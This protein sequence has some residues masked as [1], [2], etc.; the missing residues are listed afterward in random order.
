MRRLVLF[1]AFMLAACATTPSPK[2]VRY[3][4]APAERL[5]P[6]T[7]AVTVGANSAE[8]LEIND[9]GGEVPTRKPAGAVSDG[10]L[11]DLPK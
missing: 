6:V 3:A 4:V 7:V 1:L 5:E 11:S 10:G 9:W 2:A 8:G